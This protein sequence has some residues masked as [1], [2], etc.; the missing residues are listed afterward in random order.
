MD[1]PVSLKID[2]NRATWNRVADLFTHMEALPI[3]APYGVG[4]DLDLL[5]TPKGKVFLEIACGSGRS[6]KYLVNQGAK[7]VYGL[8]ISDEQ[9]KEAADF[10]AEEIK[11]GSVELIRASMEDELTIEPVDAVFSIYGFGWTQDP[12]AALAQVFNVLKPGG[13]FV[14]SWEHSFFTDVEYKDER[15]SIKQSYHDES[16]VRKDNWRDSGSTA[17]VTYRK[18]SSWFRLMRE[19][20]FEVTDFLEPAP[21]SD[22]YA[23]V[24]PKQYYSV[25][26]AE[27]VPATFIFVCRKPV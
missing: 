1:Q 13:M 20:G 25:Q 6:L 26:K 2:E 19:A 9:I 14:W 27:L 7:K 21:K 11:Q 17:H 12:E 5:P 24:D 3:W 8:D 15:F 22:M 18:T 4:E 16:S 23:H 10:N